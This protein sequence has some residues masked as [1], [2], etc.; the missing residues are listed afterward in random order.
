[1]SEPTLRRDALVDEPGLVGARWWQ[2]SVFDPVGRRSV[3]LGLLAAGT[4]FGAAALAVEACAPTTTGRRRALD[5]QRQYGWSFGAPG[6]AL[7]FDGTT[8]QPFD[9]NRLD[10]MVAELGPRVSAHRSFYV[11]TLFEA[12]A[13]QP[14]AVASGD[15][16]P[17]PPL[18]AALRPI[19]TPGMQR[20][21]DWARA[22]AEG[23]ATAEGP[24]LVVDLNG[25]DSV[26][27]AAGAMGLFDPV[28][29]FDNWP[30]P[31]G[32]VPAHLTLAAAAYYQPMF[33]QAALDDA[34]PMFVLDR[35]RL[36][37]Y[38]DDA[39]Q[40]DNRW[41]ARLPSAEVLRSWG[42]K[43]VLYVAPSR[44]LPW[45]LDDLN[46]DLVADAAAGL[47]IAAIDASAPELRRPGGASP[48]EPYAPAPRRTPFSR[49]AQGVATTA[50][51][52][53]GSVPV[54]VSLLGGTVLGVA[55]S[56]SGSWNR[57][58]GTGG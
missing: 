25:E 17:V 21:F 1:L 44:R 41:V 11:P 43:T 19:V 53:F 45:E 55:W 12:P 10:R 14:R 47:S 42:A 22:H 28:F 27:F 32:V 56:R 49:G 38:R 30:H 6:D 2:D 8:T 24:V 5:L 7:V 54:E 18:K 40:F 46:D 36:A 39:E 57:G 33:A 15:T 52:A 23:L 4:A 9:R 48:G 13:A 34:P 3:I 20:A 35:R 50:P 26:A 58:W 37:P 51:D 16:A 29:L 31:R